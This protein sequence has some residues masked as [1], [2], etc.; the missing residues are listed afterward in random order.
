MHSD[1][2]LKDSIFKETAEIE[3]PRIQLLTDLCVCVPSNK[4]VGPQ[5][6]DELVVLTNVQLRLKIHTLT[7][8]R[9]TGVR[10]DCLL[11]LV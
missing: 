11:R 10:Q 3:A 6:S 9:C 5:S 4:S 2:S 1:F 8:C 7:P